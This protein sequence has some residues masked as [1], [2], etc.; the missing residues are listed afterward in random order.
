MLM[1][2]EL[3]PELER[4]L[5][6]VADERSQ[7]LS[8]LVEE[9]MIFYLSA[10]ERESSAWVEATQGLLPKVWPEEDFTD[11]NPPDGR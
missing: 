7:P 9:A 11:W 4:R 2:V 3:K 5:Q 8:E 10:L 1:N 6:T